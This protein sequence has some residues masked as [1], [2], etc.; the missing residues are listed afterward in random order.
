MPEPAKVIPLVSHAEARAAA[1]PRA[2]L[3]YYARNG[4]A[5][6]DEICVLIGELEQAVAAFRLR[7]ALLQKKIEPPQRPAADPPPGADKQ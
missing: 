2:V 1:M 6:L 4:G 3:D 7:I 5:D